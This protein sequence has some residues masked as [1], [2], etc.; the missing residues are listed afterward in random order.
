MSTIDQE[1]QK[2]LEVLK[3]GGTILY[4]TDTVWGIGCD[5]ANEEAVGKVFRIKEREES[6][7]L[8]VLV[9]EDVK[10]NR[11]VKE[12]P[13]I[14]WDLVEVAEEP[15]TIIYTGPYNLARNLVNTEDNSV[16][17]RVTK[18]EFCQKLIRRLNKPLVSTSANRSG[19]PAPLNFKEIDPAIVN[20][21]D[22]VVNLRR[23]ES[24]KNKPSAI[25]KISVN[26]EIKIIRK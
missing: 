8:I 6:K 23:N 24:M 9:D 4:P 3:A 19:E 17:I 15:L 11:Y 7:S 1:V 5:A 25:L 22:Y 16:G 18:D 26:G 21:V 10:L 13:A 2:A 12:V 14:A 20:R